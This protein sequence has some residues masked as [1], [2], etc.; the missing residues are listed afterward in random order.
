[1]G[2]VYLAEHRL[3]GLRRA[4]KVLPPNRIAERSYLSRFY[5][6]GRATASLN[7]PNIVRIYD[8]ANDLET[9]FMVMEFVPGKDLY[10]MVST[11]GPL[12]FDLAR[13]AIVE[14]AH[15]LA[16]AHENH[17]IHRDIKPA[18]LLLTDKGQVKILD[19]GLALVK[20]E[21]S[22]ANLSAQFNENMLGTADYLAPEQAAHS[23]YI[24][25]RAD[26]YSLGCTL[27][28]LLTGR[29]PFN[30]GTVVQRIT[31]HQTSDPPPVNLSRR[32]CPAD[33]QNAIIKMMKKNPGD[34]FADCWQIIDALQ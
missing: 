15:G 1:M 31:M 11:Y 9:H 25:H 34:R 19:L 16:H 3:S 7:H 5:R 14:T 20:S 2:S 23:H 29:P 28:Y 27:Y 18:N 12:E 4:I 30:E 17:L 24:D 6:E 13:R 32:D 26:I 10:D 8:L 21:D 22:L 33:L